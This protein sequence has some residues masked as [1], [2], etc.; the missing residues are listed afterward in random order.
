MKDGVRLKHFSKDSSRRKESKRNGNER[1]KE[2]GKKKEGGLYRF[3][4]A[5]FNGKYFT[6]FLD[7]FCDEQNLI[8]LNLFFNGQ[9]L[10]S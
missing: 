9:E 10:L 8:L 2:E 1:K 7:V 4:S 3:F 6:K 5:F